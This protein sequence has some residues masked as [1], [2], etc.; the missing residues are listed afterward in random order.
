MASPPQMKP[1]GCRDSMTGHSLFSR[2]WSLHEP[3]AIRF[4][5]LMDIIDSSNDKADT[6]DSIRSR[7]YY[8]EKAMAAGG[9]SNFLVVVALLLCCRK[10]C[11]FYDP[12][13]R[14]AHLVLII[15]RVHHR[16]IFKLLAEAMRFVCIVPCRVLERRET[17]TPKRIESNLE[18][19]RETRESSAGTGFLLD[20]VRKVLL[21]Q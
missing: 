21:P 2:S 13:P 5:A 3:K 1:A 14:L 15:T 11:R 16:R 18:F 6:V 17:N 12:P 19:R 8:S 9:Q 7:T 20:P 10:C 4:F